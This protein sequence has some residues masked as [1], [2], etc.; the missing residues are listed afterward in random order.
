[1]VRLSSTTLIDSFVFDFLTQ[2]EINNSLEELTSTGR[3][4]IPKKLNYKRDGKLITNVV[5]GPD[6]LFKRGS[7]VSLNAGYNDDLAEYFKGYISDISPRLPLEF[8][9]QDEMY[10][11]KQKTITNYVRQK[12]TLAE[13]LTDILPAGYK[14]NALDVQLGWIRVKRSNVVGIFEHLR[15]HYGLTCNFRKGVLYAGLRYITTNLLELNIHDFKMDSEDCNIIDDSNLVYRRDD[16]V[17]IKLKAISID[18]KN[19]KIEV[20]VG[21]PEGDQRTMYF[22]NLSEKDLKIVAEENLDK[23][24]YEGF[25]GSFLTFLT[26]QVVPG[27]AVRMTNTKLPEKNG[28][29]LIKEVRTTWGVDGGRQEITLD[30]KVA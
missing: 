7:L 26:P 30:R 2:V 5:E 1:M 8:S 29:Y 9:L 24:K 17:R 11:L 6:P 12:M 18:T 15:T 23:L 14:F 21:D 25:F 28:V 19:E 27:D 4:T 22:Y 13:L 10:L 16:D 3:L 20:E